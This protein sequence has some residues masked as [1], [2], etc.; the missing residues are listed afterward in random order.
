MKHIKKLLNKY[1]TQLFLGA[2]VILVLG[3][4]AYSEKKGTITEKHTAFQPDLNPGLVNDTSKIQTGGTDNS[5][6]ASVSDVTT[7]GLQ[8]SSVPTINPVELLPKDNNTEWNKLNPAVNSN[9]GD[10]NLITPGPQS[11]LTMS[12]PLRNANLQLRSDPRVPQVP[13]SP[14][15]NT[16]IGPDESRRDLDIGACSK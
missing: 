10:V 6:F 14:W 5:N 13:V 15:N 9:I 8:Q 7:S 3:I 16:T 4:Y 1:S 11:Y 12:K 2:V